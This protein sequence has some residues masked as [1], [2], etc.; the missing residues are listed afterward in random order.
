MSIFQKEML[1]RVICESHDRVKIYCDLHK[2]LG[3]H[4]FQDRYAPKMAQVLLI[5]PHAKSCS[6]LLSTLQ[7][8]INQP[9]ALIQQ[10]FM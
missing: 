1:Q 9:S 5:N 4:N 10:I 2:K 6:E 3:G 7:L 8:S